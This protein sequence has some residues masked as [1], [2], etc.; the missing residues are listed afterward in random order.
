MKVGVLEFCALLA[1]LILL[2]QSSYE[3]LGH[4]VET[5]SYQNNIF[6]DSYH[7]S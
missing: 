2:E 4:G 3:V 1:S 6:G 5:K 7:F